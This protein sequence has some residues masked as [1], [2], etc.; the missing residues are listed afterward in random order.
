M[1]KIEIEKW[2]GKL[3]YVPKTYYGKDIDPDEIKNKPV[4][5]LLLSC[6]KFSNIVKPCAVN[7]EAMGKWYTM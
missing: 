5:G 7:K 3:G 6:G 2:G 4:T 1:S